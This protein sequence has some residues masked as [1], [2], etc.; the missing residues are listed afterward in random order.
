MPRS[1]DAGIGPGT[2][3]LS[4][5]LEDADDRIDDLK[6]ALRAAEKA[7]GLTMD[8]TVDSRR[9]F[10]YTGGKPADAALPSVVFLHGALRP[11][12]LDPVGPLVRST[13]ATTRW[14]WTPWAWPQR[15]AAA[16]PT[17]SRWPT[18]PCR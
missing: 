4:I 7:G 18:G 15:W 5:G 13:M 2:I 6:R 11:Q 8:V 16:L 10:A 3:R 9:V 17:S 12:R 1:P 14:H